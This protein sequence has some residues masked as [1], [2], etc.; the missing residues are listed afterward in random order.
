MVENL[1]LFGELC[2]KLEWLSGS[3]SVHLALSL[4]FVLGSLLP[5][6][7]LAISPATDHDRLCASS[8]VVLGHV[9]ALETT[10]Q[11]CFQKEGSYCGCFLRLNVQVDGVLSVS[12]EASHYPTDVGINTGNIVSLVDQRPQYPPKAVTSGSCQEVKD[13]LVGQDFI[14]SISTTYGLWGDG[15]THV[16][17]PP[18]GA[19]IWPVEKNV[20]LRK[21][22]AGN[23]YLGCHK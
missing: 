23:F 21:M 7:A 16:S 3:R 17:L 13:A 11:K 20:W 9:E 10:P 1:I 22:I 12:D 5:C 6:V 18:Y 8:H 15:T 19:V 14:I 2:I 4:S